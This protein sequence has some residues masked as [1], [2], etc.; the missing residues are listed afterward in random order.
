MKPLSIDDLTPRQL[1]I[2]ACVSAQPGRYSRSE[3]AKLLVGSQSSRAA[4]LAEHPNYGRLAGCGR[5]EITFEIDTLLQ[6][7][8]LALDHRH[9]VI[10]APRTVS[11]SS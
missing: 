6:Q 9:K 10:P 4:E 11:A 7:H 2:L 5:K 3:L 8:Y 1:I